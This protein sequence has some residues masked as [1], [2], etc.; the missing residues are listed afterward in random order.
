M[1]K[2]SVAQLPGCLDVARS[3][4]EP[5]RFRND[6]NHERLNNA[7]GSRAAVAESRGL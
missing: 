4:R 6:E 2:V 3:D 5:V 1:I 7:R